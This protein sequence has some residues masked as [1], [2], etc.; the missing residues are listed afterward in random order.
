MVNSQL[1]LPTH[2][3]INVGDDNHDFAR[4]WTFI[5][6]DGVREAQVSF[7]HSALSK[8]RERGYWFFP[9]LCFSDDEV[10]LSLSDVAHKING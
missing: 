5:V 1:L 6:L 9:F 7:L 3:I 8:T 2:T 10:E 4:F